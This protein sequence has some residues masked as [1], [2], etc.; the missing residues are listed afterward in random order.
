VVEG[1]EV[2]AEAAPYVPSNAEELA[3][4]TSLEWPSFAPLRGQTVE[5]FDRMFAA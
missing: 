4:T 5:T 2:P 3:T 1:I